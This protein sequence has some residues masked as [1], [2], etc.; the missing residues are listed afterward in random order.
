MESM[1]ITCK[2]AYWMNKN[3]IHSRMCAFEILFLFP[4]IVYSRKTI[5]LLEMKSKQKH[6]MVEWKNIL[7]SNEH[8]KSTFIAF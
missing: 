5:L 2:S 1:D 7:Q 8:I 3:K 4:N 6:R